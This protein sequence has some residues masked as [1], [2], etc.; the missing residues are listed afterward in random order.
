M[1]TSLILFQMFDKAPFKA[2]SIGSNIFAKMLTMV[3][4]ASLNLSVINFDMFVISSMKALNMPLTFSKN[5][6]LLSVKMLKTFKK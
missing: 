3:S 6:R 1:K 2:L 4:N 5:E